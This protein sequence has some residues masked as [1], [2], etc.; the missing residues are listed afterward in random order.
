MSATIQNITI[1][2]EVR[3]DRNVVGILPVLPNGAI[4][5]PLKI[6]TVLTSAAQNV[7]IHADTTMVVISSEDYGCYYRFKTSGDTNDVVNTDAG[8]Q[9]GKVLPNSQ[10]SERPVAGAT[11]ISVIGASGTA[12]VTIEQRA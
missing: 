6:L 4:P 1:G 7:A 9:R 5:A 8:N 2:E 11:H 3:S 12:R 10:R